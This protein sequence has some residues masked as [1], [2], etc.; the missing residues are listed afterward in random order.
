M[1]YHF[2]PLAKPCVLLTVAAL[3][4]VNASAATPEQKESL[5]KVT[6]TAGKI[7]DYGQQSVTITLHIPPDWHAYANPVQ[8][9]DLAANKTEVKIDAPTKLDG[10]KLNYPAGKRVTDKD[11][12]SW[13][14]YE[15]TI[16]IQ[17]SF[18][19]TAGDTGPLKVAVTYCICNDLTQK[20]LPPETALL[21]VK[22]K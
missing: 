15:G 2:S 21:E 10:L 22:S 7:G 12:G 14:V 9:E 1:V 13:H 18:K 20:C 11:I 17:A 5:V 19:R 8:N 6:A 16:E 4:F 3:A